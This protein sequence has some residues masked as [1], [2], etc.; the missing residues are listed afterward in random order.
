MTG[1]LRKV[2]LALSNNSDEE[3]LRVTFEAVRLPLRE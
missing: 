2:S 3:K 1:A